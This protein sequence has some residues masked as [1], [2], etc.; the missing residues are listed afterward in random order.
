MAWYNKYLSIY[1]KP[2]DEIPVAVLDEIREK[3]AS[4]QSGEDR[5]S[6]V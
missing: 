2:M 4:S 5:K 1:D 3:L 6:V